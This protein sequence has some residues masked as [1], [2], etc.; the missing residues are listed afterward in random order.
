MS[1][2]TVPR[3]CLFGINVNEGPLYFASPEIKEK[4]NLV[5]YDENIPGSEIV[6]SILY[7]LCNVF[8]P[9]EDIVKVRIN[10]RSL[11][12][13]LREKWNESGSIWSSF[14]LTMKSETERSYQSSFVVKINNEDNE[15]TQ[16]YT[17]DIIDFAKSFGIPCILKLVPRETNPGYMVDII[18]C[19]SQS[20]EIDRF[21]ILQVN[22]SGYHPLFNFGHSIF[23]SFDETRN[24]LDLADRHL[25]LPEIKKLKHLAE[26]YSKKTSPT[27]AAYPNPFIVVEGL[28][29][30]GKFILQVR[31]VEMRII[32]L[33]IPGSHALRF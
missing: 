12:S 7:N 13:G 14:L 20:P 24:I 18:S 6:N 16:Q 10:D 28:D 32:L 25:T 17:R 2:P 31:I 5:T 1:S 19:E 22:Y 15:N 8:P 27:K 21:E 29:G 23:K 26:E 33:F 9:Q 30:V 11:E 4:F 3:N